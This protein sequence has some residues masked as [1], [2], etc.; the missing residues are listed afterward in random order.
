MAGPEPSSAAGRAESRPRT[1]LRLVSAELG[2]GKAPL[3]EPT[4]HGYLYMA[5]S[6]QP[7]LLPLALPSAE[8]DTLIAKLKALAQRLEDSPAVLRAITFRAIVLRPTGR[9]SAYLKDRAASIHPASYDVVVLIETTSPATAREV[10]AAPLYAKMLESMRTA[11]DVVVTLTARNARRIGDVDTTRPGL[12][13]FNHFVADDT[14][15]MLQLWDYLAGW[16]VVETGLDNSVA[17]VPADGRTS[18]YA[19]V[20]WARWDVSPLRHFW[21]QLSKESFWRFVTANL[22]ANRAASMPIYHRLA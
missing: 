11:T 16:Y 14:A 8:R 5:A 3:I 6:V 15:V 21:Q 20:N 9:F 22:D 12:F 1:G 7:G 13:L 10:E 17:L 2:H 4:K 18:D 19:I